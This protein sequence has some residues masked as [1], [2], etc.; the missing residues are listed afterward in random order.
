MCIPPFSLLG[1]GPVFE[2]EFFVDPKNGTKKTNKPP[3]MQVCSQLALA[4]RKNLL[5][6]NECRSANRMNNT[7]GGIQD[8]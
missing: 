5:L 2:E 8:G 6:Y 1:Q 7:I 4:S 3:A